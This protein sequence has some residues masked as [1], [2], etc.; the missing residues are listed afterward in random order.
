MKE[1]VINILYKVN[2]FQAFFESYHEKKKILDLR[3]KYP[4]AHI[5]LDNYFLINDFNQIEIGEKVNIGPNNTFCVLN[6]LGNTQSLNTVLKIGSNTYVGEGNNIRATL[7]NI[8]IGSDCLISQ[9]VSIFSSDHGIEKGSLIRMQE[10]TTKGDVII[11]D[12]V[13]VGASSQIM[14]GVKIGAGAV[15]AA[16][17]IVTKDVEPFSLV[18]G[19]PAKHVKYRQ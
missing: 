14:S 17:S 1:I 8:I 16:G 6:G 11:G 10:W 12:G 4:K 18:M 9:N 5:H 15:I 13:W 3:K 7:G 2:I 19:V